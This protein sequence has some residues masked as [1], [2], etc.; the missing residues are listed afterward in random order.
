MIYINRIGH[1]QLDSDM[2]LPRPK[3]H[4]N[5]SGVCLPQWD[6]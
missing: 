2:M 5:L 3:P 1:D 4:L 6:T